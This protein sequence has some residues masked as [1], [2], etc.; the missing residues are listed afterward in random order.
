MTALPSIDPDTASPSALAEWIDAHGRAL[1]EDDEIDRIALRD[2]DPDTTRLRAL[3]VEQRRQAKELERQADEAERLAELVDGGEAA[4]AADLYLPPLAEFLGSEEPDDDDT[5]D[6]IVRGIVAAGAPGFIS[7]HPKSQKTLIAEDIAIAVAAGERSWCGCQIPC[8]VKVALFLI[9]DPERTTRIRM[10]QFARGHG[11]HDPRELAEWLRID[12]GPIYFDDPAHVA[13]LRRTLD[14]WR[15]GLVVLD[16]LSRIH[17]VDENSKKDM[18]PIIAA[19]A[20]LAKEYEAGV[21]AVHHWNGKGQAG[22][23]R[24]VGHKLRGTSDLFAL[25]RHVVGVDLDKESKLVTVSTDGNLPFQPE[26]FAVQLVNEELPSGRQAMRFE[27]RGD[28]RS[29]T[30]GAVEKAIIT[31]LDRAIDESGKGLSS[32]ALWLE[33]GGDE[34][35]VRRAI[36][37]LEH[38]GAIVR[39]G[40]KIG[41]YAPW[42]CAAGES[43]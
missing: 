36:A 12:V 3:A 38:A 18:G 16:S 15:P 42:V 2:Q 39:R 10:W 11:I 29:A 32:K 13:K 22:D 40:R 34:K 41:G 23:N 37:R 35:A 17:R 5:D 24:T 6:W 4:P 31:A 28:A 33:L 21:V 30:A 43:G 9:E 7:G 27:Y 8:R 26:P 1:D 19:W 20:D 25:A 14:A